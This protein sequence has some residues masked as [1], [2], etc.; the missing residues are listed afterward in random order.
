MRADRIRVEREA[1]EWD[2]PEMA[3]QLALAAGQDRGILP[4]H[5]SLLSYVKRWERGDVENISERYQ[6]LYAARSECQE[7]SS[8]RWTRPTWIAGICWVLSRGDLRPRTA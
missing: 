1:R 2:K 8:S 4:S 7:R 3:R 5:D 6:F